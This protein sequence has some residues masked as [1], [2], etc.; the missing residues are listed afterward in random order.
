MRTTIDKAGRVV[1][2]KPIR[3]AL[4]LVAGTEVD[5]EIDGAAIRIDGPPADESKLVEIDGRLVIRPTG[6]PTPADIVRR[7]REERMDYLENLGR[8]R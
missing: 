2:P 4:G 8:G 6:D 3:D 1:I 5:I 7:L